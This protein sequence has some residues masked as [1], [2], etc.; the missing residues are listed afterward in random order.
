[1]SR[2]IGGGLAGGTEPGE[3]SETTRQSGSR[4]VS[5]VSLVFLGGRAGKREFV[6]LVSLV[7]G[8]R[9]GR[10]RKEFVSMS[11][12]SPSSL[13]RARAGRREFVLLG[14]LVC[15][16]VSGWQKG[17]VSMSRLFW[18]REARGFCLERRHVHGFFPR[19]CYFCFVPVVSLGLPIFAVTFCLRASVFFVCV[20]LNLPLKK[21][22]LTTGSCFPCIR[23]Q[24][25]NVRAGS[26]ANRGVL[27]HGLRS[28]RG[29][30]ATHS[31]QH[32][33]STGR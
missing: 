1:M 3:T 11:R 20:P 25:S 6:L 30:L 12:L 32:K 16:G 18:W 4:N 23:N 19:R 22:I 9:A 7:W 33:I 15:L 17:F 21:S 13:W 2:K 14:S 31:A 28:V 10:F 27:F 5:L 24:S 26:F 29:H 8:V